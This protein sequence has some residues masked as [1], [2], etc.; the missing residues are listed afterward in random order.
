M[1]RGR[2]V[3]FMDR[4]R[5]QDPLSAG[6]TVGGFNCRYLVVPVDRAAYAFHPN[7]YLALNDKRAE[8]VIGSN[9]GSNAGI[10][11]NVCCT[12]AVS[13]EK[14][15]PS[16]RDARASSGRCSRRCENLRPTR[17]RFGIYLRRKIRPAEKCA[18]WLDQKVAL[19]KGAAFVSETALGSNSETPS[20]AECSQNRTRR[21]LF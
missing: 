2:V 7:L 13:A 19:P 14:S 4:E 17:D 18:P 6:L 1:F 16:D 3:V 5:Y 10:A 8:A 11:Y 15:E 12:F 9:N 21:T 20:R